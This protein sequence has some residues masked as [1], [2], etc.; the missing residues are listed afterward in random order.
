MSI[1]KRLI[2][3][4]V[5][6][7][8][9]CTTDTTDIFDDGHGIALYSL[10]YDASTAPDAATDYSGTASNVEF[11]VDG[12]INWGAGFNGSSSKIEINSNL[13]IA[14]NSFSFSFWI[15]CTDSTDDNYVIITEGNNGNNK[16]LHIGKISP[17]YHTNPNK[18]RF[19][20]YSNDVDSTTNVSTDGT[21]QHWVCTFDASSTTQ[22]VYLNGNLENTRISSSNFT[23]TSN[24]QIGGLTSWGS[25]NGFNGS[26]DQVRVF[27]KALSQTEVGTLYAET[28]CVYTATTTDN[29]YPTTNTAYYK[30][31]NSA[32]DEKGSYDGTESNITYEFGRFGTAAV[33]NGSNSKIT[34]PSLLSSSY[35]GSVSYSAWFKTSNTANTI[36]TI[37]VTD[38]TT[39]SISGK[40][41]L[42]AVSYS[43]GTS[44]LLEL[45]GY[46]FPT[47]SLFGTTNVADGNWH[48]VVL[49]LDNPNATL[50]V[51]LD[52]DYSSPEITKA[53]SSSNI[54][55][56]KVF[57]ED[58]TIGSQGA[59]RFFDGSIDQVR[60]FSSAL[61][62]DQVEGLFNDEKQAYIT[63]SASDPFGDSS[64]VAFYKME[65]NSNDSTGSNNGSDTS[66]TYS[67]SDALFDSYSAVFDGSSSIITTSLNKSSYSSL[68]Y[69][70]WI[71]T[72]STSQQRIIDASSGNSQNR[73]CL[74]T[75]FDGSK[76]IRY[77]SIGDD[78]Y[79]TGNLNTLLGDWFHVVVTDGGGNDVNLYINGELVTFTKV[80]SNGGYLNPS[81]TLFGAGRKT[82]NDIGNYFSGDLDQVR[83][84]NR[85]L[86]G[87]EVFKLYAE[88]IN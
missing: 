10:D 7:T 27:S 48:N 52:G 39:G 44:G 25:N 28:A 9:S 67:T 13:N 37:I 15:A 77:I 79:D 82:T 14:N 41:L 80:I 34:A 19:G 1:G 63:K 3:T 56:D 22:K 54:T 11:G 81:N 46:N 73:Q 26:I 53:L 49:V 72:S 20:F 69:S 85:V 2:S 78:F 57:S 59:I 5:S 18:L 12:Q 60:I 17:S 23:G 43:G 31:D 71:K 42:L 50:K 29:D 45:T 8:P 30:L 64:E 87:D 75:R 88:V 55:L 4:G 33:F 47:F 70:V 86:E 16:N 76:G 66:M 68:S 40:V 21:W 74:F 38:D 62:S 36:K 83:I 6:A 24:L 84:F 65:N 32:E 51:Y 61:T 35:N 58:W